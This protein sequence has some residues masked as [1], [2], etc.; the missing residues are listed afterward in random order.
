MYRFAQYHNYMYIFAVYIYA[1]CGLLKAEAKVGKWKFYRRLVICID[2]LFN[3]YI[4]MR[5]VD[6][7]ESPV[8]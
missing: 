4:Y 6:R 5:Y 1:V 2:L 8:T 7:S 3:I